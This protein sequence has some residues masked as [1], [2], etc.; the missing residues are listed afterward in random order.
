MHLHFKKKL[1]KR[2]CAM[3]TVVLRNMIGIATKKKNTKKP[4]Q[5]KKTHLNKGIVDKLS[6]ILFSLPAY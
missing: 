1:N 2:S 3:D 4:N 6:L 5:K